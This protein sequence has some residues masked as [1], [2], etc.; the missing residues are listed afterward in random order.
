MKGGTF[1]LGETVLPRPVIDHD[2]DHSKLVLKAVLADRKH[3]KDPVT[4]GYAASWGPK[5]HLRDFIPPHYSVDSLLFHITQVHPMIDFLP[6]D[7]PA[8]LTESIT[9]IMDGKVMK[10]N[11]QAREYMTPTVTGKDL[12]PNKITIKVKG[13]SPPTMTV[14]ERNALADSC[15]RAKFHI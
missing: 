3:L 13:L 5:L 15:K 1:S 7:S 2:T 14:D 4:L 8:D 11:L 12:Y 9:L 10:G 6:E